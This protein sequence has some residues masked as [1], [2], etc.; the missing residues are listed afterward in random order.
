MNQAESTEAK[1]NNGKNSKEE[2]DNEEADEELQSSGLKDE[3]IQ[4]TKQEIIQQRTR[5]TIQKILENFPETGQ[6]ERKL[7]SGNL[8]R[9]LI[10]SPK[11]AT[12]SK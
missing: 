6:R 2:S 1:Q 8:P 9:E 3:E 5:D 11:R 10:Y 4:H 12:T 7:A